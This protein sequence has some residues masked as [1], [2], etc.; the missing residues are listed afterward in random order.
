MGFAAFAPPIAALYYVHEWHGIWW[1]Q[2]SLLLLMMLQPILI[3]AS[4]RGYNSLPTSPRDRIKLAMSIAYGV[5]LS[6]GFWL[7]VGYG[8]F[9]T[10]IESDEKSAMESLC[11]VYMAAD[12]YSRD[13]GGFFPESMATW[14][15][16]LQDRCRAYYWTEGGANHVVNGYSFDY[17][18]EPS[19][20]TVQGCRVAQELRRDS[21][22]CCL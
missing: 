20:K 21:S 19:D 1:I 15:A 12:V 13:H 7:F 18:G 5:A 2:G 8:N 11:S 4:I 14:D 16:E 22:A 9:P 17:R 3:G 10:P 6:L